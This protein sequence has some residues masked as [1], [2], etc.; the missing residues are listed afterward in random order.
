MSERVGATAVGKRE[1]NADH[2]SHMQPVLVQTA[3]TA[4]V[5][6]GFKINSEAIPEVSWLS[7]SS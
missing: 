4:N 1:A 5:F 6:L 7:R 2:K 3:L